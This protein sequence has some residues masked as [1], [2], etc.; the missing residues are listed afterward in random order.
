MFDSF[1]ARGLCCY[2]WY[3]SYVASRN[4]VGPNRLLVLVDWI[5]ANILSISI[6][7]LDEELVQS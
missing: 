5:I 3:Q 1:Y 2:I 6:I 7:H 4:P